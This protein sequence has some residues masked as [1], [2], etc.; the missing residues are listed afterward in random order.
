MPLT[1]LPWTQKA[2]N[3]S[4][5]ERTI[6]NSASCG[7]LCGLHRLTLWISAG[8]RNFIKQ[9]GRCVEHFFLQP[10]DLTVRAQLHIMTCK[11]EDTQ[12]PLCVKVWCCHWAVWHLTAGC[13]IHWGSCH[14][15][16]TTGN[17]LT[18][19]KHQRVCVL[20]DS[21]PEENVMTVLV[22]TSSNF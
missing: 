12:I 10:V 19:L 11:E 6:F 8:I 4:H 18:S 7:S 5:R 9:C 17:W 22:V 13:H 14:C 3:L 15:L 16:H 20:G 1:H 2:L 21:H